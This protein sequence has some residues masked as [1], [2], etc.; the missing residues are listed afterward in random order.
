MLIRSVPSKLHATSQRQHVPAH[1]QAA[2]ATPGANRMIR[3]DQC[4]VFHQSSGS[5]TLWRL[6]WWFVQTGSAGLEWGYLPGWFY[7]Q[8]SADS[9][10]LCSKNQWDPP[11]MAQGKEENRKRKGDLSFR[12]WALQRPTPD[13]NSNSSMAIHL[14]ILGTPQ[15]LQPNDQ[16]LHIIQAQIVNIFPGNPKWY[17][18][19]LGTT[20]KTEISILST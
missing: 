4:P 1:L 13:P 10:L 6:S 5:M 20:T 7:G 17:T 3:G 9:P 19:S 11:Q 18:A 8:G 15:Q 12:S 16:I 14:L 2:P